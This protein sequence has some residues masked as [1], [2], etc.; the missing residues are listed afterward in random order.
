MDL[1]PVAA[2]DLTVSYEFL[3]A[4]ILELSGYA[5]KDIRSLYL[6]PT[7][8]AD[9]DD[10]FCTN[11]RWNLPEDEERDDG[12]SFIHWTSVIKGI[13]GDEELNALLLGAPLLG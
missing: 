8:K 3:A 11:G 9:R 10:V 12:K 6:T 13:H 4:E 1:H 7:E 2:F 5:E